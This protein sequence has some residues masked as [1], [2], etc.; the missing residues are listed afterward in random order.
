MDIFVQPI[1]FPLYLELIQNNISV[2]TKFLQNIWKRLYRLNQNFYINYEEN[3]FWK[4]LSYFLW[5]YY[6]TNKLLPHN[7]HTYKYVIHRCVL[8]SYTHTQKKEQKRVPIFS[9]ILSPCHKKSYQQIVWPILMASVS[10]WI[11]SITFLP[12]TIL[13]PLKSL[14]MSHKNITIFL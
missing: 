6:L 14:H 13:C 8:T 10:Y 3:T 7:V 12:L 1:C 11:A 9:R 4:L 2:W 5:E